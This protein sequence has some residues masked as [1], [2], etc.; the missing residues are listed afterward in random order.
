[1]KSVFFY[2]TNILKNVL[3]HIYI[4]PN[5]QKLHI[6]LAYISKGANNSLKNIPKGAS[7]NM[8]RK[9]LAFTPIFF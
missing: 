9:R 1:M 7:I 8:N 5:M 4:Y 2:V 6:Y 3:L